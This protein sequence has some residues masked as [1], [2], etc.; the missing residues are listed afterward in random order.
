MVGVRDPDEAH[1][2]FAGCERN[3]QAFG[4]LNWATEIMLGVHD[5]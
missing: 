4:L 2:V 1:G 5:K 3:K